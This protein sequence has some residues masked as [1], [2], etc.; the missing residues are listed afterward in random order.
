MECSPVNNFQRNSE[1]EEMD[2]Q[3]YI[4]E[5]DQIRKKENVPNVEY[6]QRTQEINNEKDV[7]NCLKSEESILTETDFLQQENDLAKESDLLEIDQTI[8]EGCK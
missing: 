1:E 8:S 5:K 2:V 4:V 3:Q 7:D 6:D